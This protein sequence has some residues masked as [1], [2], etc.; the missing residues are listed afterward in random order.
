LGGLNKTCRRKLAGFFKNYDDDKKEFLLPGIGLAARSFPSLWNPTLPQEDYSS[1]PDVLA[2]GGL[3]VIAGSI[4]IAL[5]ARRN[6][7]KGNLL[8]KEKTV[9][10]TPQLSTRHQIPYLGVR[11]KF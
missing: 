6:K 8:L 11:I 1:G 2:I 9:T 10:L 3:A 4:P 7:K 5:A